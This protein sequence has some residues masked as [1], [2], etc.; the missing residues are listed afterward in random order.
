[1]KEPAFPQND[2]LVNSINNHAGMTLRD[3]FAGQTIMGTAVTVDDYNKLARWAYE[4]AD[5][6]LLERSK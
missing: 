6:M 4:I 1:M 5:A 3:Y 2:A